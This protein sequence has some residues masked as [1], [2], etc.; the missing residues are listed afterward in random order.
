MSCIYGP[1]QFGNEDQGWVAHFV[2]RALQRLPLI[3]YGDGLQVRDVLF[4]D[5]LVDA[6]LRAQANI[7]Q[8]SGQS[9]N[10]GG[11]PERTLSLLELLDRIEHICG[12]RPPLRFEDWRRGDQRYYVSDTRKFQTA[13]GWRPRVSVEEGVLRLRDW[14]LELTGKGAEQV[15]TAG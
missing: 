9:F 7:A 12:V 5:D 8:L 10:I 6:F 15:A 2:L 13:T 11:G 14:L 1:R 4:V 3:L